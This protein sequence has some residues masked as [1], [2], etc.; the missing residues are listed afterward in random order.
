MP[1]HPAPPCSPSRPGKGVPLPLYRP[2]KEVTPAPPLSCPPPP[3]RP[4]KGVRHPHKDLG[5]GTPCPTPARPRKGVS[6]HLRMDMGRGTPTPPPP[7]LERGTLTW[8]WEWIPTIEVWTG[9]QTEN[10][11][12]PHPSDAG[13]NNHISIEYSVTEWIV[14]NL[15]TWIF[16]A[17]TVHV[18]INLQCC[19]RRTPAIL[20][21]A[22]WK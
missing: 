16:V 10:I 12:F 14:K 4:E 11:T 8:T 13:G 5:R 3:P 19:S 6:P 2:V 22:R 15:P 1:F 7:N 18:L 17:N 9:T 21:F 20:S